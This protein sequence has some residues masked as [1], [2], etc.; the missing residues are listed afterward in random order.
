MHQIGGILYSSEENEVQV[1]RLLFL[2]L[3][4]R[5]LNRSRYHDTILKPKLEAILFEFD[6][7]LRWVT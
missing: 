3:F 6:W 7:N 1:V 2:V 5:P 4:N